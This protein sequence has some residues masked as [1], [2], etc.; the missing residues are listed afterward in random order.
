MAFEY[1]AYE[2]ETS[3]GNE[4]NAQFLNRRHLRQEENPFDLDHEAFRKLYRVSPDLCDFL[5]ESLD[6]HVRGSRVTA[7]STEKLVS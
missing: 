2:L 6:V 4:N 7:I 5:V 1:L 3:Q